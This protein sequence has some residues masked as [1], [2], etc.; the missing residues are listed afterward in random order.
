MGHIVKGYRR[1]TYTSLSNVIKECLYLNSYKIDDINFY[2]YNS[3]KLD[4]TS[5]DKSFVNKIAIFNEFKDI[6]YICGY[7]VN[8]LKR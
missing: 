1:G 8:D 2:G 5:I 3:G 6:I 4:L 7:I